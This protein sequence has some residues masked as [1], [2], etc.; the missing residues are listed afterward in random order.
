M[1]QAQLYDLYS[2]WAERPDQASSLLSH[3][4]GNFDIFEDDRRLIN[5]LYFVVPSF[6]NQHFTCFIFFQENTF[7]KNRLGDLAL[8]HTEYHVEKPDLSYIQHLLACLS[9]S[10]LL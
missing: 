10:P 4:I 2:Q 5:R 6:T 3:P 1:T 8:I 9:L 7:R